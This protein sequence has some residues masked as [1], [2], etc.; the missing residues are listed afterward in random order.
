MLSCWSSSKALGRVP[1]TSSSVIA[2]LDPAIHLYAK[3][4]DP[5]VKPAG[6]G[7][8]GADQLHRDML[9]AGGNMENP[10]YPDLHAHIAALERNGLL[11]R[12]QRPINKDTEMLALV[13]WQ[14][15]GGIAESQRKGFLF[16][17]VIDS[18]GRR[19]DIPVAV[20]ILK[21][22]HYPEA[23]ELATSLGAS[24]GHVTRLTPA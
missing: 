4:M 11:F 5:R 2:G 3:K 13:R 8:K 1:L 23:D 19:Y 9:T 21:V 12:V 6:D 20:G 16:E 22:R 18:T 24:A 7:A 17:N 10:K 15:R 14:F